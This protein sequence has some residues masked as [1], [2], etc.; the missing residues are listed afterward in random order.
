MSLFQLSVLLGLVYIDGSHDIGLLM[1]N[2]LLFL[3]VEL[4]DLHLLGNHLL[5]EVAQLY[6]FGKLLDPDLSN[7]FV[8]VHDLLNLLGELGISGFLSSSQLLL[9]LILCK[10][11]LLGLLNDSL[12]KL[13]DEEVWQSIGVWCD[14]R[15]LSGI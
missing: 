2:L 12:L 1:L 5:L 9:E 15:K 13:L 3:M 14:V 6:L 10:S 11:V 7:L 4:S 8:V